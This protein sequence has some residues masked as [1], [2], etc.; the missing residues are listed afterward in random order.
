MS[1]KLKTKTLLIVK[2]GLKKSIFSTF[3][4]YEEFPSIYRRSFQENITRSLI[5]Q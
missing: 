4:R 3:E 1:P 2:D 5:Q